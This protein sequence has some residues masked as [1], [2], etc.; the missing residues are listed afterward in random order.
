MNT[1]IFLPVFLL[2]F[3]SLTFAQQSYNDVDP[4]L[5]NHTL[6]GRSDLVLLNSRPDF[7]Y[8]I[9]YTFFQNDTTLQFG[10]TGEGPNHVISTDGVTGN[11][12]MGSPSD[13]ARDETV[14]GTME[15][16]GDTSI[17]VKLYVSQ[18]ING[19]WSVNA[20]TID[21]LKKSASQVSQLMEVRMA[22]GYLDGNP[23]K[24]IVIAYNLPDNTQLIKIR[25]FK[26]DSATAVP[27]EMTSIQDDTLPS[28]LG[29]Q[30]IFDIAAGDF[31]GDGLDEICVV[32]NEGLQST[33]MHTPA[34]VSLGLKAYDFDWTSKVFVPKGS[35]DDTWEVTTDITK[36]PVSVDQVVLTA[37]DFNGDGRSEAVFG[38]S[39]YCSPG[40]EAFYIQPF[41][42]SGNLMSFSVNFGNFLNIEN[43]GSLGNTSMSFASGDIDRDGRDELV[44][45][46]TSHV[47]IYRLSLTLSLSSLANFQSF[48]KPG[49][50]SHHRIAIGDVDGDTTFSDSSSANWYPEVVTSEFTVNP[51]NSGYSGAGNY[52]H[53]KVYTLTN[54]ATFTIGLASDLVEN[55]AGAVSPTTMADGGIL[56]PYLRGNAIRLGIPREL[57]V[58]SLVEPAVILNAPPIHFES[59]GDSTYDI[60]KSYPVGTG[61]NFYSQ[62]SKSI[63]SQ[64]ELSTNEHSDWGVSAGLSIDKSFLGIGVKASI[65]T[66][67]GEK[68]NKNRRYD[69]TLTVNQNL[70][71][72]WD[73]NIFATVTD[74]VL[75]E[76]PV[77][78]LGLFKGNVMAAIPH[79]KEPMW[80][81]SNDRLNGNYIIVNH[82]PGNLLSYQNF[83]APENNPDV[84]A[85]IAKGPWFSINQTYQAGNTW[86]LTSQT[87][88]QEGSDTTR[89]YGISASASVDFWG[90]KLETE[91][92]YN[93]GSINTHTTTVTQTINMTAQFGAIDPAYTWATYNILPYAYWSLS[94]PLVLDYMVDLPTGGVGGSFWQANYSQKPDLTFNCYYRYLQQKGLGV[95]PAL[96]DW[97]KEIEVRPETPREGD[98]VTVLTKI[99]N[100]SLVA[101]S[102]PVSVRFYYGSSDSGGNI[103]R[104]LAGDTV[105]MTTSPV[106]ARGDQVLPP[107]IWRVPTGLNTS[108]TMLVAVID[109]DDSIDEIRKD[110]N[111]GWCRLRVAD[112][113]TG[114]KEQGNKALSF[115]LL[116]NYPNPFN[117]ATTIRYEL[118]SNSRVSLKIYNLLGQIVQTLADGV[119]S[120][121]YKEVS[122]NASKFSSGVY[123]Y[124][125][126]AASVS[127][128]GKMYTEV[129]KMILMK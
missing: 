16:L 54:P 1:R 15:S 129:K 99:H 39:L 124:R 61:S 4:F 63:S 95:Q 81:A 66:K 118:P 10:V 121:G 98:T 38:F 8:D 50:M 34:Y 125:L 74:Y 2:C 100:Y 116:Q 45:A 27:A 111:K 60:C 69:T 26:L 33:F 120:A 114:V 5:C 90:V 106:A 19:V 55:Y 42:L 51:V 122:W 13:Q 97:T 84:S 75:F 53:I 17:I 52:H 123:F 6:G 71:T 12:L 105:F 36:N 79:P 67:Y 102:G 25:L 22:S 70:T 72:T 76:Y 62:Y 92:Q 68:F 7:G 9:G 35:R 119:Q 14:C 3:V 30:T 127:Y 82:E 91:G 128:P 64:W 126:D 20:V 77:Y 23:Q 37:G 47:G 24:D 49:Y 44:C 65:K 83:G 93:G 115:R 46:G 78:A 59:I 28:N 85:L 41:S 103:V 104:S 29:A 43:S 57:F 109:Q 88:Y 48:G 110:N 18:L 21:S 94:G 86:G 31:D 96:K 89:D 107:L 40:P 80:I 56:L 58:S 117:P 112:L 32:K 73:D 87:I 11:F 108:D 113:V 101:T